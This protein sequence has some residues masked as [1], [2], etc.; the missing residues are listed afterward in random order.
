ML[1]RKV[2]KNLQL[3]HFVEV[4]IIKN[5]YLSDVADAIAAKRN[6]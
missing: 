3:F 1:R 2:V 5:S 6:T 4:L